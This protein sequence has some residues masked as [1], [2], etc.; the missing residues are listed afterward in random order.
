MQVRLL[1]LLTALFLTTPA[2]N[3]RVN[4]HGTPSSNSSEEK[5]VSGKNL[6]E[7]AVIVAVQNT[8]GPHAFVRDEATQEWR[9]LSEEEHSSFINSNLL[10]LQLKVN[11]LLAKLSKETEDLQNPALSEDSLQKILSDFSKSREQLENTFM[12]YK[13]KALARITPNGENADKSQT[14]SWVIYGD[15]NSDPKKLLASF[16]LTKSKALTCEFNFNSK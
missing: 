6:M 13:T 16:L 7:D 8:E 3:K 4:S 14:L 1:L 2:C 15:K 10:L 5:I 12:E 11:A 9:V